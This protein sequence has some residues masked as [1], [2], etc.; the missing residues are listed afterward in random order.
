MKRLDEFMPEYEFSERHRIAIAAPADRIDRAFRDVTLADMPVVRGLMW[1][2]GIR[3]P[4]AER[5][6]LAQMVTA[7]EL[8]EDV[9]GGG[10]IFRLRGR[11][12][13]LR[14]REREG[15]EADAV[16]DFRVEPGGL[17]TETRVHV[18]DPVAR[19][20]F[21]RYWRVIR[22]FSGLIRILLLR[23]AKRRAEAMH[24]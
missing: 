16:A 1:L 14:Y 22:P 19:R 23:A 21:A 2:R 13:S 4:R 10:L 24:A 11:F 3:G 15:P 8:L 7:G 17:S 5:P 9:P 12:W 18:E 6:F 20:K